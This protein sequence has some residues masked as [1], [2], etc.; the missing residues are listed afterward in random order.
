MDV[1]DAPESDFRHIELVG[2]WLRSVRTELD[3]KRE[4][5][6]KWQAEN[7]IPDLWAVA[8]QERDFLQA[9]SVFDGA[10]TEFTFE[11]QTYI[12]A[13]LDEMRAF[14]LASAD[15]AKG[16]RELIAAQI[17]FT[18]EAAK[19]L[20]RTDWKGVMIGAFFTIVAAATIRPDSARQ[21]WHMIA[22]AF[23]PL[24]TKLLR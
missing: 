14:L 15:L 9:A 16:Q 8:A 1:W 12:S 6:E 5:L 7:D 24:F 18:K 20:G 19:R 3:R 2:Q 22:E 10:N 11:E 23:T 13:R 21:L 4:E 17:E